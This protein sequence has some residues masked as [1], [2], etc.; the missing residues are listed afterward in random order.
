V[1]NPS[2]NRVSWDGTDVE[3]VS[4]NLTV[5]ASGVKI[6]PDTGTTLVD[7]KAYAFSVATGVLAAGGIDSVANG[8]TL[9]VH[10]TWTGT[11]TRNCN[12]GFT[13]NANGGVPATMTLQDSGAASQFQVTTGGGASSFLLT[14]TAGSWD[15]KFTISSGGLIMGG[16]TGGDKGTGT[17]NVQN[18]IYKNNSAYGNPDYVFEHWATG[19][20][21]RFA[22]N[23]G[24]VTYA[25]LLPLTALERY[26]REHYHFPQI[27]HDSVGLFARGDVALELLEQTALYLFDHEER[28]TALERRLAA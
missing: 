24:A 22:K 2:G 12:L 7:T 25:G 13:V 6:S 28:L 26:V 14:S 10:S 3:I 19:K 16:P 1:G 20:I 21:E 27:S 15:K 11:G 17:I 4:A 8:R 23:E 9:F 5:N 18:D